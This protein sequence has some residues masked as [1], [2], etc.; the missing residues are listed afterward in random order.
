MSQLE[1]RCPDAAMLTTRRS[2]RRIALGRAAEGAESV[3][4]VAGNAAVAVGVVHASG[5]G[6]T[7]VKL[8]RLPR[9]SAGRTV[10]EIA[11]AQ[12]ERKPG[13][14]DDSYLG[15]GKWKSIVHKYSSIKEQYA[16]KKLK[17]HVE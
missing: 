10:R 9:A 8:P 16:G 3:G 15:G 17:V 11:K 14:V 4:G 1:N 7:V 6:G 12:A 13:P 2:G 5:A